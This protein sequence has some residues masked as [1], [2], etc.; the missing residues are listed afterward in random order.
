MCGICGIIHEDRQASVSAE[1]LDAMTDS[2]VHRGPDG[3]GIHLDG[4]VGL[5]HR[6]LSIIDLVTGDQPMYNEDRSV[7]IVFNGEIYNYKEI[8]PALVAITWQVNPTPRSSCIC[9]KITETTAST[10]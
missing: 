3:R 7:V 5:G 8:Q 4:H 10:T 2:L 1:L 9:M 6:R